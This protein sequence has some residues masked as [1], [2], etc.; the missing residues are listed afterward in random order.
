MRNESIEEQHVAAFHGNDT[1]FA[2][3]KHVIRDAEVAVVVH[4][5]AAWAF[6][7]AGK[8]FDRAAVL[9]DV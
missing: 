5:M 1:G 8:D 6:P 3:G 4:L 9:V 2:S 7:C